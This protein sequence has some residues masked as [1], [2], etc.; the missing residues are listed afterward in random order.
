M[1]ITCT[2]ISHFEQQRHV[3][4]Y[5]I[6]L[7]SADVTVQGGSCNSIGEISIKL[8]SNI[9]PWT[10]AWK[11]LHRELDNTHAWHKICV[12]T[13]ELFPQTLFCDNEKW[14]RGET[15]TNLSS[16]A[17]WYS[18]A[19]FL[20]LKRTLWK[21]VVVDEDNHFSGKLRREN[22]FRLRSSLKSSGE[23]A[24]LKLKRYLNH[25]RLCFYWSKSVC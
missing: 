12:L 11:I 3:L 17:I 9:V 13:C 1:Q 6:L 19:V 23:C 4:T 15:K 16:N 18:W 2:I 14:Y 21:R 20:W 8:T 22:I 24:S 7:S 5:E 10:A 25:W